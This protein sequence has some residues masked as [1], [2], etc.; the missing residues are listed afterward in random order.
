MLLLGIVTLAAGCQVPA[1][2]FACGDGALLSRSR[3]GT[4]TRQILADTAVEFTYH[5]VACT[6][7]TACESADVLHGLGAGLAGKRL[8]CL[9][10]GPSAPLQLAAY[11]PD[12]GALERDLRTLTG[13]DLQPAPVH[14]YPDGGEALAALEQL[15]DH[16]TRRI[17]VLMFIWDNDP[18]GWEVAQHLAARARADLPVRVLIDGGGNLIFGAPTTGTVAEVNRVVCWLAAQPHVEVLRTRNGCARFDHRKLVLVDGQAAWSGGRNFTQRSFFGQHDLSYTLAGPL[19]A[20]LAET[21]EHSWQAQGGAPR[22][23]GCPETDQ[24]PALP[25]PEANAWARLVHTEAGCNQLE[26]ALHRA[27]DDAHQHVF[28]ENVYFSDGRLVA[29]LIDARRRG[30]D[31][32]A[33]LTIQSD[34]DLFNRVNR[35]TAN[36]LLQAGVRVYLY[37]GM[38]H[39]K[40]L[41]VDGCWAYTGSAN[42]DPLSM[43]HD[44]ELGLAIGAGPVITEL[45][46][47]LFQQDFRPEW[48][49]HAPLPLTAGDCAAELLAS[50]FL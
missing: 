29:Q 26:D 17:D 32:R 6:R 20:E 10:R 19:A 15:I 48:E 33:I 39:V 47:R 8:A 23:A 14:L 3:E 28:A 12:P 50:L 38:T 25:W 34:S 43:R 42:F 4:L 45:E 11:N 35:V 49:L 2:R 46:E 41:V 7:A 18:L 24:V 27:V 9:H 44:R 16:A 40:A 22:A 31:V 5:P 21:F 36:R 30:V 1:A 13:K 37:P